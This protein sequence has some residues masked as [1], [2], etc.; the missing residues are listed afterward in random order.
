MKPLQQEWR[1]RCSPSESV[2]AT[3]LTFYTELRKN[4]ERCQSCTDQNNHEDGPCEAPDE[5]VMDRKPAEVGV[6]VTL[7]VET[8]CQTC[9]FRKGNKFTVE[10]QLK[11]HI[12]LIEQL[13]RKQADSVFSFSPSFSSF[14][15]WSFAMSTAVF[16]DLAHTG[17]QSR[18]PLLLLL[19]IFPQRSQ[20]HQ[21]R[22]VPARR[23]AFSCCSS[24]G[25][26][27]CVFGNFSACAGLTGDNCRYAPAD[28][29][30][31]PNVAVV[32]VPHLRQHAVDV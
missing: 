3:P 30:V 16:T 22:Q 5:R 9:R 14:A 20:P 17:L 18:L 29:V 6:S 23:P 24:Y 28:G 1:S 7:G 12:F 32:D 21:T 13:Q 26:S 15:M 8:Y 19:Y 25:P 11:Y 2:E 31:E 27:V 10:T 4:A